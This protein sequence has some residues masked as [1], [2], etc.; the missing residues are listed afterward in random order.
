MGKSEHGPDML[1]CL[2]Y[3]HTIQQVGKLFTTVLLLPDGSPTAPK[4]TISVLSARDD[5]KPWENAYCIATSLSWPNKNHR[6]F[7]AALLRALYDHDA[8]LTK[9]KFLDITQG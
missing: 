5:R 7:E 1:D 2:A 9:Q 4:C 6:L 8:Q 3:L